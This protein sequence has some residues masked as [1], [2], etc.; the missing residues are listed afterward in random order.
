M[1][2]DV[3]V[4]AVDDCAGRRAHTATIP[5]SAA[6]ADPNYNGIAR[7]QRH[8]AH[9]GQRHP[10]VVVTSP[11]A[12]TDVTEGGAT[13][14][15][16]VVLATQPTANVTVTLVSGAQA[17]ADP[18]QLALHPGQL[19]RSPDVTV[20]AV[21]DALAEGTHTATI[22]H[23]AAS[24]GPIQRHGVASVTVHITDNDSP[25]VVVT[26]SSGG[27]DVTEGGAADNYSVV[28]A[29]QPTANVT[30]TL[31]SGAQATANPTV[32]LFTP[33]NWN[34]PQAV[35]VTAVDDALAEGRTQLRSSTAWQA[36]M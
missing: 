12:C 4:T 7:C 6:S 2:Q 32:L 35:A 18:T 3:A 33:A 10:G 31:V 29:T 21:D 13:D 9:H 17:T 28:L 1:P 16:S 27:T 26:E 30:V 24:A 19:E 15:Y 34:V 8:G 14:N 36:R 23:S 25:G 22:Q 5:H 20:T 11:A